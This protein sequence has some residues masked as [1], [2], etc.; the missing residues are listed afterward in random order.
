[1]VMLSNTN[2][3]FAVREL[4]ALLAVGLGDWLDFGVIVGILLLNVFVGFYQ[5]KQ[6]ADV[7][8]SLKGDIAMRATVVRDGQEQQIPARELVPGDII[9]TCRSTR[10][11]PPS[12]ELCSWLRGVPDL[13]SGHPRRGPNHTRRLPAHAKKDDEE[14][15]DYE[16]AH[17]GLT[18]IACDQSAITGESLAVDKYMGDMLFYTAGCKRGKAYA[19][20]TTSAR[21]SF[22]GKTANLAQGTKDRG[23]F[24]Q[25]MDSVYLVNRACHVLDPGSLDWRVLSPR[26][27][28]HP[29]R[30]DTSP[31]HTGI[32]HHPDSEEIS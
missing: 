25:A 8:A 4:A 11:P 5:E 12:S 7:V 15:F 1:M 23:H 9:S 27:H 31:L 16:H 3:V 28:C 10:L 30:T 24:K 20:I 18:L 13:P 22:T 29:G 21:Y 14:D 2:V 6:A 26:S 32:V 19:I 17:Y